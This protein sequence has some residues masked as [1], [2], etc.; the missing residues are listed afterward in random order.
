MVL[1]MKRPSSSERISKAD[2]IRYLPLLPYV[3]VCRNADPLT[4]RFIEGA[5]PAGAMIMI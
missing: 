4:Y 1:L 3:M 2:I 5:I